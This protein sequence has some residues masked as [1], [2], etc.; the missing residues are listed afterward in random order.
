[1][2]TS[3]PILWSR[4]LLLLVVI[5]CCNMIIVFVWWGCMFLGLFGCGRTK[6]GLMFGGR[7]A[8]C[9]MRRGMLSCFVTM[10]FSCC[11]GIMLW[12]LHFGELIIGTLYCCWHN[13]SLHLHQSLTAYYPPWPPKKSTTTYLFTYLWQKYTALRRI[14]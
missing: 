9:V 5:V 12:T 13:Y 2:H 4:N 10:R 3:T 8:P 1:M 11:C 6:V 7:I 14:N